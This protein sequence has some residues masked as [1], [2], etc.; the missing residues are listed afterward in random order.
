M[1]LYNDADQLGKE[2]KQK[3]RASKAME[4]AAA[5]KANDEAKKAAKRH[6]EDKQQGMI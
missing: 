3:Q 6:M 2:V 1:S 4:K 5:K